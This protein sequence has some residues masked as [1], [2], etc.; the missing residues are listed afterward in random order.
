MREDCTMTDI[1]DDASNMEQE[2]L[3]IALLKHAAKQ[4]VLSRTFCLDCDI[5]IPKERLAVV[6]GCLRCVDCQE[7]HERKR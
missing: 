2:N 3:R 4:S 1:A 5:V 7:L 6:R